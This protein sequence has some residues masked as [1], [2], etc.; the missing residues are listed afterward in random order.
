MLGGALP[1]S[2][3]HHVPV[4]KK[5]KQQQQQQQQKTTTTFCIGLSANAPFHNFT[6]NNPLFLLFD[7][8]FPTQS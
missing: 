7:Q 4:K 6:S 5:K 3:K 8:N 1:L 2:G